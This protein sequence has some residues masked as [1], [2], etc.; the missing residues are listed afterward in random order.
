M[1][2]YLVGTLISIEAFVLQL[3]S[4][5]KGDFFFY[6]I[7]GICF[8]SICLI[9]SIEYTIKLYFGSLFSAIFVASSF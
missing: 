9:S 6:L 8:C 5:V 2:L 7:I 4:L 3:R 1:H